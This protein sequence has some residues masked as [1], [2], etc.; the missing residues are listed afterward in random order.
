MGED[1]LGLTIS[2]SG[3][4]ANE[5]RVDL[6]DISQA[7]IGFQRSIALTTHLVL[8]D[9][10]ITQAPSLKGATIH[11]LPPIDGSWKMNTIVVLTGIY[12]LGT[13]QNNSP[14]GHLIFSLYDYVVSESLGVRVDLN[15]SLGAI[16]EEAKKKN[17]ELPEIKQHQADSLIEKCSTAIHEIHRPIYKTGTARRADI[18]GV[19]GSRT[20]PLQTAFTLET[21]AYIH[22]TRTSEA[23][24]QFIGRVSSYNSNTYKGRIYVQEFGHPVSFELSKEAR[25]ERV[26]E[27]V[28]TSLQT[29]ALR[30]YDDAEGVVFFSAFLRTSRTGRLKGL[31]IT[32]VSDEPI[33]PET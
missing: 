32:R 25:S 4:L 29:N 30:R 26:V 2:F 1:V 8:N 22:E 12:S 19:I 20:L 21:W 6:Y 9:E 18:S 10:I 14:L 11:A 33:S 27:L 13:L 16:Y 7:M 5:H 15:K 3:G 28:T 31:L 24:Q 17:Q 23:P